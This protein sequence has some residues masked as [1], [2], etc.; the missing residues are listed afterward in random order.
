MLPPKVTID[1]AHVEEKE[2]DIV[3][4]FQDPTISTRL[5][6]ITVKG[7]YIS[8][9]GS[10]QQKIT[11]WNNLEITVPIHSHNVILSPFRT[12]LNTEGTPTDT[13]S[14]SFDELKSN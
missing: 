14:L 10:L 6:P 13:L 9:N 12:L 8:I 2:G 11:T 4:Y 5:H 1:V 3:Y 7:L